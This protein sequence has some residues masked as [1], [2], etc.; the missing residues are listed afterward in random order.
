MTERI[1]Q[2]TEHD[3]PQV[4]ELFL[5]YIEWLIRMAE[6][7]WEY[8]APVTAAEAVDRIMADI[9]R[10]M[11]PGGRLLLARDDLG[12]VGC[13]CAWTMRPGLAEIKRVYVRPRGRGRGIGRALMQT[14]IADLRNAGYTRAWLDSAGFMTAAVK[15]YRSLG[16][17]DIPPYEESETPRAMRHQ[18]AFLELT[19]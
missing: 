3:L 15:L 2:A 16:F 11:P 7:N 1:T 9:Q 10:F 6:A 18:A 17:N 13:A 19:L 4:Q 12:V 8:T 14:L 5:E